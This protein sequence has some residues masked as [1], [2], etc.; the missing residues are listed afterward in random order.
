MAKGKGS[1]AIS[2]RNRPDVASKSV[3]DAL[4]VDILDDENSEEEQEQQRQQQQQLQ[5]ST[6]SQPTTPSKK[7]R[8]RQLKKQRSANRLLSPASA[9]TSS[10]FDDQGTDSD[11]SSISPAVASAPPVPRLL[12]TPTTNG[13][14]KSSL[15][16]Q[17]PR[18]PDNDP[19][20]EDDEEEPFKVV[21]KKASQSTSSKPATKAQQQPKPAVVA[22]TSFPPPTL[23]SSSPVTVP[24]PQLPPTTTTTADALPE[25][26]PAAPESVSSSDGEYQAG[27]ED[28]DIS[29]DEEEPSSSS[30][31]AGTNGIL[32]PALAAASTP[33]SVTPSASASAS[34]SSPRA[35]S[36]LPANSPVPA[37]PISPSSPS[38]PVATTAPGEAYTG[39]DH[40]PSKKIQSIITRTMYSLLMIGGFIAILSMGHVYVIMLVFACQ[41]AVFSEL[42]GLFDAGTQPQPSGLAQTE[43]DKVREERRRGRREERDRWSRRIS[44]YFFAATNYFLYGE[45]LIYY[46]KHILTLQAGFLP[47]TFSFA[48]HHR[49]LSF[50]LYIIG[51]VSFVANLKRNQLRRQFGLFGWIHMSLLLV[52]VSSHF[53]VNNILEGLIWFWVPACL[54]IMNDI[55]AY[56]C[57]ML[58]GRHQLIKLSPKKTVEGFVGAFF[59]TMIFA[60]FWG[61]FFMRFNYMVCPVQDLATNIFS[62]M[63][64]TRNQVFLW[65]EFPLPAW[66]VTTLQTLTTKKFTSIPW[67]P[68]QLHAVVMAIFAS[69]V[70]PFGGFFASGFKRAFN[71]KDFG[72]SIPG[73]GGMTDRMD[74][75]FLMGLFSYVY[76]ASLIRETHVTVASVLATA[77]SSLTTEEQIE[78]VA[79]LTKFLAAKGIKAVKPW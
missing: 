11:V 13:K 36:P 66:A 71:I 27:Y 25:P 2:A 51:F 62:E 15:A 28:D 45:S 5:D 73:H 20:Q 42:S 9:L 61:T 47:T 6:V 77:V 48:Q 8:K 32:T 18:H 76:Y 70:A 68:F 57:G 41:A 54:V 16:A 26:H 14:S 37:S 24:E 43:R 65:R 23:P 58:F 79:D 39:A 40:E 52:I 22:S 50:G 69:L 49:L 1:S 4:A 64:C 7:A 33:L 55:A 21:S 19:E 59:V 17:H 67:A 34:A 60:F 38:S 29:D 3:F 12:L 31:G 30:G 75:Q 35:A 10:Q 44:W 74:C 78:L 63:K 53:I 46:F 56:V 72:A